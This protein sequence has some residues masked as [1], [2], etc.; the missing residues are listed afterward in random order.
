[1]ELLSASI[2]IDN[3]YAGEVTNYYAT[4]SPS[5]DLAN[6]VDFV[7]TFPDIYD[8]SGLAECSCNVFKAS[9]S[10]SHDFLN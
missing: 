2:T 3:S 5:Q 4:L 6:N 7:I 9:C 1:M 10:V 8:L